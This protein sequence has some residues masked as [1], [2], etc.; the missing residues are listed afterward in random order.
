MCIHYRPS[1]PPSHTEPSPGIATVSNHDISGR[2]SANVAFGME[3]SNQE[4]VSQNTRSVE[5]NNPNSISTASSFLRDEYSSDDDEDNSADEDDDSIENELQTDEEIEQ[6]MLS[7]AV[8][9]VSALLASVGRDSNSSNIPRSIV[10]DEVDQLIVENNISTSDKNAPDESAIS[11]ELFAVG[12]RAVIANSSLKVSPTS[13][14]QHISR[15]R[16]DD[17]LNKSK[18]SDLSEKE[19]STA[20]VRI[21]SVYMCADN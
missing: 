14:G 17:G 2:N 3:S 5:R 4:S 21:K 8:S 15:R 1:L 13:S 20:H 18:F 12:S 16:F 6:E 9:A 10:T 7:G 19:R 11:P